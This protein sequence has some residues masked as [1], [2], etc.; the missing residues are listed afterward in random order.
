MAAHDLV[1]P[2]RTRTLRRTAL[3]VCARA[4]LGMSRF[5]KAT[6]FAA[7]LLAAEVPEDA[8]ARA[9]AKKEV[10]TLLRDVQRRAAE[11]KRSNRS[12]AKA[13]SEFVQSAMAASGQEDGMAAMLR[14]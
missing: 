14:Q 4:C 8:E 7:R 5:G 9:A 13:L 12:L 11:V 3:N 6:T 1:E 2:D 10:R